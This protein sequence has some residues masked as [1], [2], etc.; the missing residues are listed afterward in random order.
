MF[1]ELARGKDV[2]APPHETKNMS[3]EIKTRNRRQTFVVIVLR[4]WFIKIQMLIGR[5]FILNHGLLR[6][7]LTR[8]I[9]KGETVA[10]HIAQKHRPITT[11]FSGTLIDRSPQSRHIFKCLR[12]EFCFDYIKGLVG[13]CEPNCQVGRLANLTNRSMLSSLCVFEQARV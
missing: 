4:S 2:F 5:S 9:S 10:L 3:V 13:I 12:D 1:S 6:I 11:F 7:N 8:S